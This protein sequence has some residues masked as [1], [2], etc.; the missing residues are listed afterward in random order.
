MNVLD[1]KVIQVVLGSYKPVIG[2]SLAVVSL[3]SY[4]DY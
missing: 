2:F 3:R 1:N 4:S